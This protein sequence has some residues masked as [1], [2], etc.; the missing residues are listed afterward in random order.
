V[1]LDFDDTPFDNSVVP[2]TVERAC[3]TIGDAVEALDSAALL[4][5][6]IA[7][8]NSYWPEVERR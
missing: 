1:S 5:A 7:A 3:D 8:W 6:N 2:A 4:Q